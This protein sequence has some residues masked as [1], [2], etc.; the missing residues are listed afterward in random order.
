MSN[1]SKVPFLKRCGLTLEEL[2]KAA[3]APDA[4]EAARGQIFSVL[5]L[6]DVMLTHRDHPSVATA[7]GRLELVRVALQDD[8]LTIA[9]VRVPSNNG[10]DRGLETVDARFY[11]L[12][13]VAM[14]G[15]AVFM[16]LKAL[17]TSVADEKFS[18][19]EGSVVLY[20]DA[21]KGRRMLRASGFA[22]NNCQS[23]GWIFHAT[24]A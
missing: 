19:A 11:A 2:A 12:K 24:E 17:P 16:L 5:M 13:T 4:P 9:F 22:G 1:I 6:N 10:A 23:A 21:S 15:F 3:N 7:M 14:D 18:P 20:E 8:L